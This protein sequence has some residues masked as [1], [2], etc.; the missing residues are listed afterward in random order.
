M[1]LTHFDEKGA[2][3]MVNVGEKPI[4]ARTAIAVGSIYVN[5][6]AFAAIKIGSNKKGDIL[7]TSRIAGIMAAKNT[8]NVI[9]LCHTIALSKCSIDF[10]II[11]QTK[12][13]KATCTAATN[14]QTGVEMEALTGVSVA[15]LTIYDMCKAVDQSMTISEICLLHKEG[16]RRGTFTRKDT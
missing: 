13:V 14:G 6:D 11:E 7:G 2:A 3:I 4:T 5:S 12:S 9:P 15:L 1:E 10:E 8:A 16:G